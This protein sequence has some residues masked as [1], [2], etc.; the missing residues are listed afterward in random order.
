MVLSEFTSPLFY[1]GVYPDQIALKYHYFRLVSNLV[2][3]VICLPTIPWDRHKLQTLCTTSCL[4]ITSQELCVYG[5]ILGL[6]P[7]VVLSQFYSPLFYVGVYRDQNA[8]K[9]H[10]SR[11]VFSL[12][13]VVICLPTTP[14]D[15][16]KS[17]TLCSTSCLIITSQGLY[18]YEYT[19]NRIPGYELWSLVFC[20]LC[21]GY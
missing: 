8:L 9:Y 7:S 12:V 19:L 4:I 18:V 3:F 15:R 6:I 21:E 16:H 10:Y 1:V 20:F 13:L 5:N 11:L 14:W 17:Q 2:L